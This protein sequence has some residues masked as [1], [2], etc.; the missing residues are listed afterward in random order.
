MIRIT[1]SISLDESE[2]EERFIR[3]PG[4]GGQ[5]VNKVASAV[6]LRL[7]VEG[8]RSLPDRVKDRLRSLAG[9]RMT[10]DGVLI[11]EARRHRSQHRNREDAL[12]RLVALIRKAARPGKKRKATKPTK[13][14]RKRRLEQKR[15]H[16]QK[17][18]ARRKPIP[19]PDE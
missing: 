5:N 8:S 11:I 6:Q 15:R 1:R 9:Q 10:D 7:D 17:K 13:A 2:L 3:S 16:S 19:R 4:P 18:R 12:E 14:S